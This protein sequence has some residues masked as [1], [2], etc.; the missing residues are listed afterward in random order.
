MLSSIIFCQR[1]SPENEAD[2]SLL[3]TNSRYLKP[4]ALHPKHAEMM[5][6]LVATFLLHL[7]PSINKAATFHPQ[8]RQMENEPVAVISK[9]EFIPT[10]EAE[11]IVGSLI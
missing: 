2:F 10:H 1:D 3:S 11:Q 4:P 5:I 8:L 9:S 7:Y 6:E